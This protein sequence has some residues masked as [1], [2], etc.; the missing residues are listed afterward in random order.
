[1][2]IGFHSSLDEEQLFSKSCL[3]HT[4]N[5]FVSEGWFSCDIFAVCL[6]AKPE[7]EFK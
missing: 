6:L 1:M 4:I 3:V 7:A 2:S 5:Y